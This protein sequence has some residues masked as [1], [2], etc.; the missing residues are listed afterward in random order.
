MPEPLSYF[1]CIK[2]RYSLK[3]FLNSPIIVCTLSDKSLLALVVAAM[4]MSPRIKK[5]RVRGGVVNPNYIMGQFKKRP[6]KLLL[7]NVVVFTLWLDHRERRQRHKLTPT[8]SQSCS[9]QNN[10]GVV[11][12]KF[13]NKFVHKCQCYYPSL[14][15]SIPL[16]TVTSDV[17]LLTE[18]L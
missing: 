14:D 15:Q 12:S 9:I 17:S 1:G 7:S 6:C 2:Y 8:V 11:S 4:L 18:Q 13:I 16:V 3:M 5:I 10:I